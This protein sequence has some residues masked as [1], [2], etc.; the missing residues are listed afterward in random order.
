MKKTLLF[1]LLAAAAFSAEGY[2]VLNKIKV[3]GT[4]GWDYPSVGPATQ[5]V[6]GWHGGILAV[7]DLKAGKVDGQST[8]LHGGHGN[9]VASHP[10]KGFLSN[11]QPNSGS[12]FARK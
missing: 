12:T 3:G 8:Q 2:K 7:A 5:R 10:G 9:P 1:T 6:F 4:G 11:G